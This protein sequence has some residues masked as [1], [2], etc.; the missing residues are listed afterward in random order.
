[1]EDESTYEDYNSILLINLIVEIV[2][3]ITLAQADA[4][5]RQDVSQQENH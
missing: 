3:R 5:Q 4:T 1:M 2:V